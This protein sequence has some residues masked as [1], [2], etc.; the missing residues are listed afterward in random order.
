MIVSA[1]YSTG[2]RRPVVVAIGILVRGGRILVAR[3]P[4]RAHQGGLWEF[5][6]G[7]VG[8]GETPAR[9]L[10]REFRE[11]VGLRVRVTAP[12]T[13][14]HH[15]YPDRRVHLIPYGCRCG[16]GRAR[17]L[18]GTRVRWVRV[19]ALPGLRFPAANRRLI[20]SLAGRWRVR[21]GAVSGSIPCL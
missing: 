10:V 8:P 9:A 18:A 1:E 3:R 6:G 7:K 20:R 15:R 5:P 16:A 12:L 14:I 13:P 2:A 19:R 4:A 11:E 21:A 17:P